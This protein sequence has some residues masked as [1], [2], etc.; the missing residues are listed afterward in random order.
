AVLAVTCWA[1]P[2]ESLVIVGVSVISM[3]FAY[4]RYQSRVASWGEDVQRLSKEG[5]IRARDAL[6]GIKEV[7]VGG[8][9]RY[10][11]ERFDATRSA[12]S[13]R[14]IGQADLQ[15]APRLALEGAFIAIILSLVAVLSLRGN[16]KEV[17]PLI[18]LY[19]YAGFRLLPTVSR[20]WAAMNAIRFSASATRQVFDDVGRL[21]VGGEVCDAPRPALEFS[22]S[23]KLQDVSFRYPSGQSDALSGIDVEIGRGQLIAIVGSSG[24]GKS[25]LVDVLLGLQSPDSGAVLVDGRDIAKYRRE[26][27]A[28]I[29]YVPQSVFI[30]D[31]TLRRNVAFGVADELIDEVGVRAALE[32]AQLTQA[33]G[34]LPEGLEGR[35]GERGSRLSG[36]QRQRVGIARALYAGRKVL[37]LDEAMSALD[38][39]TERELNETLCRLRGS[40]TIVVI[41]HRLGVLSECDLVLMMADGKVLSAGSFSQLYAAEPAFKQLVDAAH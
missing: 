9:E 41:T 20:I 23:I 3:G 29:G 4:R 15:Q 36:G 32:E 33:I 12:L 14:L 40:H 18:G 10:F 27:Q 8:L 16:H 6:E 34:A 17:L 25:T 24:S 38:T 37:V 21:A 28:N 5:M 39:L 30:L 2:S 31:D 26:W 22:G 11:C 13:E 1:S 7:R 35:L 19:A